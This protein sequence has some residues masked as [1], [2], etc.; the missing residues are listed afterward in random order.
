MTKYPRLHA[1]VSLRSTALASTDGERVSFVVTNLSAGGALLVGASFEPGTELDVEISSG[2][3]ETTTVKGR[4]VRRETLPDGEP[5]VGVTFLDVSP[6]ADAALT[7]VVTDG[8]KALGAR[9]LGLVRSDLQRRGVTD[10][11]QVADEL[12]KIKEEQA[13]AH[14]FLSDLY[15][16]DGSDTT[17]T[18]VSA[19]TGERRDCIV[20]SLN[21]YLG[22]N[23]SPRVIEQVR[24]AVARYGTGCGTSAPSGGLNSMHRR[25]EETVAEMTGKPRAVVFPTGYSANLGALST[26]PGP[27]D[28]LLLDR[29]AHASMIDGARLSGRKWLAFKHNDVADLADKLRRY[30]P[31]HE[32]I[33]VAV[34]SA[35]SMSGDLAPL[36]EIALLKKE[37]PFLLYVDEAHTFGFYGEG[38]RG[39]CHEQGVTADV[40]FIMTTLSK[41]TASIGGVVAAEEKYCTLL[42]AGANSY[43]FQAC[44]TPPDA[45]AILAS[46][47]ELRENPAHARA[48]HE[49]NRIMREQLVREG[50]NLGASR[51]PV[52]PVYVPDLEKLYRLCAKL[53]LDGIYSVPVVYPAVGVDAGRIR[54]I[55]NASHTR[56]QI[57][58][59]VKALATHARELRILRA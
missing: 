59:T 10:V 14:P 46:L 24:E 28:L 3:G 17:A 44:L 55:V 37:H 52:I 51:S 21:L 1:R 40:D 6:E 35:Y 34:E 43:I 47:Q 33:F 27:R 57:D 48:L 16:R 22:L 15:T 4:V 25:I 7:R 32:N 29:E 20:W 18:I 53:Y 38:G 31:H 23:R 39:Y 11:R 30:G 9:I 58:R 13:L 19:T 42:Q 50:F 36:R 54:F 26:L 49:N 45:A 5:A 2:A 56:G 41:A 12:Q 8:F